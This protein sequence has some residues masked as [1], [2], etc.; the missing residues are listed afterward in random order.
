V[1][2]PGPEPLYGYRM[3]D[4]DDL[5]ARLREARKSQGR[6][7]Y[8]LARRIGVASGTLSDNLSGKHRMDARNLVALADVLGYDLALIPRDTARPLSA[9]PAPDLS[10]VRGS[11][12]T[13][14]HGHLTGEHD[15]MFHA[16]DCPVRAAW[17]AWRKTWPEAQA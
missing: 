11:G 3:R 12:C 7:I 1:T 5:I 14:D 6:N 2:A 13:C 15:G 17:N 10:S 8:P 16:P 4:Y 9:T